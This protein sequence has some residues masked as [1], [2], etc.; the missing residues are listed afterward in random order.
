MCTPTT[1]VQ[2]LESLYIDHNTN[3][4]LLE[5]AGEPFKG[6][7]CAGPPDG[8]L[9]Q[10]LLVIHGKLSVDGFGMVLVQCLAEWMK[11][12]YF[13]LVSRTELCYSPSYSHTIIPWTGPKDNPGVPRDCR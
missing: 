6:F 3:Q 2:N 12:K 11:E 7:L 1:A 13:G 10:A 4:A 9:Y 8:L 5:W